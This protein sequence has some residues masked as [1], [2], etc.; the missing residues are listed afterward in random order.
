MY[1][2]DLMNATE[3]VCEYQQSQS[4]DSRER[5]HNLTSFSPS[6]QNCVSLTVPAEGRT[7][8]PSSDALSKRPDCNLCSTV[9]SDSQHLQATPGSNSNMIN[10]S[11]QISDDLTQLTPNAEMVNKRAETSPTGM[12]LQNA[13]DM[14][15]S[16]RETSLPSIEQEGHGDDL[17]NLN[18]TETTK[19]LSDTPC[20]GNG[21]TYVYSTQIHVRSQSSSSQGEKERQKESTND[22]GK[23]K[24]P[25]INHSRP[26]S[27]TPS[28]ASKHT[29]ENIQGKSRGG[30]MEHAVRIGK[31]GTSSEVS[32][33][34]VCVPVQI[35]SLCFVREQDIFAGTRAGHVLLFAVPSCHGVF[36]LG[37]CGPK[38]GEEI[39]PEFL[40][41]A[42]RP[43]KDAVSYV[44]MSQ[45]SNTF[46][47]SDRIAV[48]LW[49]AGGRSLAM[50]IEPCHDQKVNS[51]FSLLGQLCIYKCF[52]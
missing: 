15:I 47:S 37:E 31:T 44:T 10:S 8:Q 17:N 29:T 49:S 25:D 3:S 27:R 14:N 30:L 9:D 18:I 45:D 51:F 21:V 32:H 26:G 5:I 41:D 50:K 38:Y 4:L 16:V 7:K 34:E 1:L 24:L 12:E 48:C 22:G 42:P 39:T 52:R 13:S 36:A 23:L 6:L 33:A 28:F 19:V 40:K 11:L 46:I 43:H 2:W 35:T 20:S